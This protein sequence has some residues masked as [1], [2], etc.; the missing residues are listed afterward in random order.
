MYLLERNEVEFRRDWSGKTFCDTTITYSQLFR[1][2]KKHKF[3]KELFDNALTNQ[4]FNLI[5]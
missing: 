3:V 1:G 2:K 5:F 4:Y